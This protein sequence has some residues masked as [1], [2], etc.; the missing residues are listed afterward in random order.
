MSSSEKKGVMVPPVLVD[1]TG[2]GVKD[3]LMNSFDGDVVLF[4][5]ETLAVSYTHL[6]L[7][8]KVNV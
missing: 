3:I 4:N 6:T 2:D 1:M 7:P 8:T 5:G